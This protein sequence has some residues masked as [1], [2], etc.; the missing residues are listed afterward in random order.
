MI[1]SLI[2]E[3]SLDPKGFS[4]G[5]Q[6]TTQALRNLETSAGRSAKVVE[7][8]F[9]RMVFAVTAMMERPTATII[10]GLHRI[11]R[12]A[13]EAHQ[14]VT[15]VGEKGRQAGQTIE[16]GAL[17][18]AVA[19]RALAGSALIAYA[20]VALLDKGMKAAIDSAQKVFGT[21]VGAA[22]AGMPIGE[23]SAISQA[24][25]VAGN[26]PEAETQGWL[27]RMTQ[28]REDIARGI[29]HSEDQI[30][31][32]K[33]GLNAQMAPEEMLREL[34]L[35]FR[36]ESSAM[37]ISEGGSLGLSPQQVLALKSL[38]AN[39]P[40]A[41]A[42]QQQTA[43]TPQQ[44]KAS[45]DLLQATNRLDLAWQNLTRDFLTAADPTLT[46]L[47]NGLTDFL[48]ALDNLGS[49]IKSI[50]DEIS[51][52]GS[53][54]T[55]DLFVIF[56]AIGD[57]LNG[58]FSKIPGDLGKL[59][60]LQH[61]M[62]GNTASTAS[63]P[64]PAPDLSQ[65]FSRMSPAQVAVLTE[66]RKR[67]SSGNYKAINTKDSQG[68]A[69]PQ[70][71]WHYGAWQFDDATWQTATN[72]IGVGGQYAHASDAPPNVQDQAAAWTYLKRGAEPWAAS[73]PYPNVPNQQQ[74]WLSGA[75]PGTAVAAAANA[76]NQVSAVRAG[77][78]TFGAVSGPT[79]VD[80][81]VN[82]SFGDITV[83]T[84]AT[85]GQGTADALSQTINRNLMISYSNTGLD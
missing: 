21:G 65:E 85:D 39:F 72:A 83:H 34:A 57:L 43:M 9:S 82:A 78:P 27:A 6:K 62:H 67:E 48:N 52:I 56:R 61:I 73:G 18:G 81:S 64:S 16:A 20:A 4:E 75:P 26:A 40:S 28:I 46:S 24:L 5:Q 13:R 71:K 30:A 63:L 51:G 12:P 50:T 14:A 33:L 60:D 2:V 70:S 17:G 84:A 29:P 77:Q 11:V 10:S 53:N 76:N 1:D 54:E 66:I 45:Q 32:G 80:R 22:A 15:N 42:A 37:A 69:A 49:V 7:D 44:L 23:F 55:N 59:S 38:G 3:L 79:S 41:V 47:I 25:L 8:D 74:S 58:N 36:R 19:M 68:N 31:L 35:R